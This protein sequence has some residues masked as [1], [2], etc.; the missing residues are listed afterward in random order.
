M[1]VSQPPEVVS[2]NTTHCDV[3]FT[4]DIQQ[5]SLCLGD[6]RIITSYFQEGVLVC[7]D[8]ELTSETYPIANSS[9]ITPHIEVALTQAGVMDYTVY[10]EKGCHCLSDIMIVADD[11]V[12]DLK[13]VLFSK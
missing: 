2:Y 12:V 3:T 10:V 8:Q 11:R 1:I 5:V 4:V 6:K 9:D 7:P 13:T